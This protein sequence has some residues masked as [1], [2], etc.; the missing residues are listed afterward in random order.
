M[1]ISFSY[2]IIVDIYFFTV[3][4][5]YKKVILKSTGYIL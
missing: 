3:I 2:Y 4:L 5:S 1:L